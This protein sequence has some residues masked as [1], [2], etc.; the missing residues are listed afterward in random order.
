M[1]SSSWWIPCMVILWMP[2]QVI[3]QTNPLS[4]EEAVALFVQ[5]SL[6]H[7]LAKI[8]ELRRQGEAQQSRAYYNP[9]FSITSEQ[10][11]TGTLNYEERTYQLSQSI[12]VLGQPFL[13]TKSA[14]RSSEAARLAFQFD[15]SLLIQLVKNLYTEYWYLQHKLE[16]FDQ[17]LDVVD[18]VLQTAKD[19]Q[20]E[21]IT[22][23][24]E[25][26]R[27]TIEKNRY[28]RL[29]NEVELKRIQTG[30]QLSSL[31]TPYNETTSELHVQSWMSV[32]PIIVDEDLLR[33]YAIQ[34]RADLLAME[35]M[36]EAL[37][38][39]YRIEKQDR[40][41]DLRLN[42]G[43]KNQ[44]DGTRGF[45]IGA[46]IQLPIFN[47]NSGNIIMAEAEQRSAETSLLIK[48]RTIR[49]EVDIAL[50]RIH[51][52]YLQWDDM[53]QNP[54]S[55]QMLETARAAYQEGRYSLVEL[56]DATMAYV[57]GQSFTYRI[58]A[59]YNLAL[60]ELDTIT[61]GNLL[62]NQTNIDQ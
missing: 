55:P 16:V 41:P 50:V 27:F 45:V 8:E 25:V 42:V 39:N 9:E 17:A 36:S 22:S 28:V 57:D 34:N 5:N 40:F 35:L 33:E 1:S 51:N 30:K 7:E 47:R 10:F 4:M 43:Y 21:G 3:S 26:Q 31:I 52:L 38:L 44:S 14:N 56:L 24:I 61:S 37:K 62:L 11:N 58:T 18:Q 12:Q 32:D 54:I 46:G 13:R 60:F 23:G 29:R 15:R 59:D 48:R 53:Q 2:L 49:D 20:A 6:Q 19:R